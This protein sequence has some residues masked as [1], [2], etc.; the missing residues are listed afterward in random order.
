MTSHVE[1]SRQPVFNYTRGRPSDSFLTDDGSRRRGSID[2]SGQLRP[3]VEIALE[4][5]RYP[6]NNRVVGRVWCHPKLEVEVK[7]NMAVQLVGAA[8]KKRSSL[9]RK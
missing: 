4:C 3:S 9:E 1:T 2:G 5:V 6:E 7:T 8:Q